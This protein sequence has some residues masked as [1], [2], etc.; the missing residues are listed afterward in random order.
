M[1][2][3]WKQSSTYVNVLLTALTSK[4][5]F[6][7]PI[8]FGLLLYGKQFHNQKWP[9]RLLYLEPVLVHVARIYL[10]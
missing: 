2:L 4:T 5:R 1:I 6:N 8:I 3:D 7:T 9:V 10:H